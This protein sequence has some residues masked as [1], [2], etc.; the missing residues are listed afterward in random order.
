MKRK[1][2]LLIAAL[3]LLTMMA[4]TGEM[5]GQ[6]AVNT[7]LWEETW[8]GGDANETPS[9]YGFEGTTVYG[10]ATLTYAQSSTNTKLYAEALA[11]GTSPELLLS[12][13]NQTWTISNIPTGQATEM[14]LTFLSNKATFDVTSTTTGITISGSE[15]S[16]TI[17]A[18]NVTSF[19]LTIKNTGSSNARID[20]ILLKVTTAGG[21]SDPT[22]T[23][24]DSGTGNIGNYA[25]NTEI[26]RDFTVTQSNL[27]APISLSATND[28]TFT[29]NNEPAT[30]IPAG[31]GSTVVTWHFTPTAVGQFTSEI[32]ASS[33]ETSAT[34]TYL[35][36]AFTPHNVNIATMEHGTVEA[37][38][39]SGIQGTYITLT[40]TPDQ[41]YELEELT[42]LDGNNNEI[43]VNNLNRFQ[44]PDSDVTVNAT[45]VEATPT[46]TVTD[47]LTNSNTIGETTNNYS[48]W[49]ATGISGAEYA[50][51]SAG[52]NGTIQL[53]SNNSNSGIVSTTS[54][55][56]VKKVTVT[57]NSNTADARTLNIYGSNTAY[58]AA[59]DLYGNNAGTL[60]G[61]LNKG[62]EET[63]L[64]ITDDYAYIG[65]RSASGA[66]YLDKIEI[67]WETSGTPTCVA[68]TFTPAAGTYYETQN[69]TITSATEGSTIYYTLDG[70]DP[71]I[72]SNVYS[73]ALSISETTTVKA[74][75]VKE[76]YNNSTVSTALYTI[77]LPLVATPTFTPAAGTYTE[78]QSVT[79]ACTTEGATI[80]YTLDGTDPTT[81]SSVYSSALS[82]SETTTVKAM[83][84]KSGMTNSEIGTALYTIEPALNTMQAI[85]DRATE[86][87]STAT[88]VNIA[89]QNWVV[90]GVSTNGK[91]VF[92]TDG[93]KGFVIFNNGAD[94]GFTTGDV[95][96]GTVNCKVQ[97]YNGFAELTQL[98][99]TTTGLSIA[100][101]GTVTAADID[102]ADLSGV[103]TGALLHYDNLT[104]SVDN[105][106]YYL[107]DGTTTIQVYNALYAFDALE[108]G[109][110]YNITGVYQQYN[111]TKEILPRSAD[112]IEE[113]TVIVPT[114]IIS[115][116]IVDVPAEGGE[117]TLTV[118][119]EQFTEIVADVYF[120]DAQGEE[121]TYDWITAEINDDNNVDYLVEPNE[122]EARTAYFKVYA[123][124]DNA[125]EVYSNLVTVNQAKYVVDYAE[126][127][128]E[129]DGNG[130][131]DLPNGFTVSGLGTYSSSPAMKFDGTGDYAILKINERPGTL[132]FDIKGNTFSGGT[133]TVQTSEDGVTYTDLGTYTELGNTQSE[134]FDNLG[135]N[136]RYIKWIYTEKVN[137]NV[138]LGNI[139][140]A[141]YVEPVLIPSI[142][143]DPAAVSADAEEHDGTLDLTYENLTITSMDDFD[144]QYYDA[145][146]EETTEPDWVEVLIAEQDPT[147]GE[148][149]VVSYYMIENEGDARTAYFKVYALDGEEVVYSNLVTINQAAYVPTPTGVTYT[150]VTNASQIESGKHYI[151]VGYK[152]SIPYAM[153]LQKANN[154]G[155]IEILVNEE[156]ATVS[157][158]DVYEFVINGPTVVEN[159]SYY[160]IYD[161]L[162]PGYLYAPGNNNYLKTQTT[163][164]DNGMW[165]VEF[166]NYVAIIKAKVENKNW[167]RFNT[168]GNNDPLFSCYGSGQT[169]IYLFVKDNDTD[170][171]YYGC[172][173]TYSGDYA[174]PADETI[175]IGAGSVMEVTGNLTNTTTSNLIIKDGGQ[176]IHT[177]DVQA[178]LLK[179]YD[180]APWPSSKG[181]DGWYT[182]ASP[183]NGADVSVVTTTANYDFYKY[184]EA[185]YKWLN[186]KVAAH[187]ITTFE[188]GVGY[189]YATSEDKQGSFAGTMKATNANIEK[190]L[191]YA[192]TVASL[193]GFNLMGNP[194]TRNLTNGDVKLGDSYLTTYY[195]VEGGSELVA[196]QIDTYPIKPGQGFMVQA[197]AENQ[198]LVFN[199]GSAKGHSANNGYI[200][201]AVGNESFNDMA[202]INVAN[203]NTLRKMTLNADSPKVY[204][205]NN[206]LD[207][208][209]ARVEGLSG[210]MP[211]CFQTKNIGTYTITIQA[212]ELDVEYL[213]LIDNVLHEDIDMLLE[214]SYSFIASGH[215][216][217]ARFTLV[218]K[219]NANIDEIEVNDIFAYQNG[220][221]I[222]VNGNGEL[223]VFDVTGRMV[224][225][226]KINGIQTVNVPATGMYIFRMVG[227]SVQT[228][229]IVVR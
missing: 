159:I 80:Y 37:D 33:G 111:S 42:V 180:A 82:I 7:T 16:W 208:A 72:S 30:S 88:N 200:S 222:I 22:I 203:G 153:G 221:D 15:K 150:L 1:F 189:L 196:R 140:L 160:T 207:Y 137:G 58:T 115:D 216:Y 46:T 3:A 79:I 210:S 192:C 178:T 66:L 183:V 206:N 43:E 6:A 106:K 21:G 143:V 70:N 69:V 50:G 179:D 55:G 144:I 96:S 158:N 110:K 164:T 204:V 139:N 128:F 171:E 36:Y 201:I 20:N 93:T 147:I 44:M 59:S 54:G 185:E 57:W 126:L 226:T 211:V 167:M 23:L 73:E 166:D 163:N 229:K 161:K 127:P 49:T 41:G 95:L 35:G 223:Q 75:A 13:S 60:L 53:R 227:E 225:N 67:D 109:K 212:N 84:V 217:A 154:R 149:Y 5:W 61:T 26:T 188:Q 205:M 94:M 123:L 156:V 215:D 176:L 90:S 122:G 112:D 173:L 193:K 175:T 157:S 51:Q 125:E 11:G 71:T 48:E 24:S 83:A 220:S 190:D 184:D 162:T 34:C 12:K 38:P 182:I 195:V 8:T 118:S 76:G 14:S 19:N 228:Q 186:Q 10:N 99:S 213:H 86:V 119:Y 198:K 142:T 145:Q 120:C 27:T 133:F 64:N 100:T 169:D 219:A 91:N 47:V 17:S 85:F 39:T 130:S 202:Y 28:G 131:G 108:N 116:D 103:N 18:N 77:T 40:V 197:T 135:E 170:Y 74:M 194:F 129:Y 92:V 62:N 209:A 132:S 152:N 138:A 104:C 146:G 9:A 224:M 177:G 63:N 68:P 98:N 97:L 165:T 151:I 78:T 107:S 101:G 172:E 87:G 105:N 4:T 136:V 31:D 148:G 168:N 191:S 52:G 199:P 81:S 117:G 121:A 102:M 2:T 45:F 29:I 181:V 25:V 187:G 134:E 155:A 124:D 89:L 56:K 218:F 141:K 214:P 32:T 65:I 114:I 113:A 174:I